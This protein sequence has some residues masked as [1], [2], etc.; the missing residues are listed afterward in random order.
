VR[1][2]FTLIELVVALSIASVLTLAMG[3]VLVVASRAA[4]AASDRM[5]RS[6]H[7]ARALDVLAD[8]ATTAIGVQTFNPFGRVD[9]TVP[10]RT[11]DGLPESVSVRA[12]SGSIVLAR[13]DV[14]ANETLVDGVSLFTVTA[15][16]RDH[17][18][19][20]LD[21]EIRLADDYDNPIRR[22]VL[23]PNRPEVP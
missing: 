18:I 21:L 8:E 6:A 13:S 10:D 17:R 16:T 4:P 12:S 15:S 20:R 19:T 11:G 3:S 5:V 23:L 22:T 9:F 2:G 14:T 1:R 7:A